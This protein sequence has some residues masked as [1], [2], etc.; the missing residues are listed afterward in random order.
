MKTKLVLKEIRHAVV[1]F[2]VLILGC[3]GLSLIFSEPLDDRITLS[4]LILLKVLGF[5]A[6][7]LARF[8][9]IKTFEP[10]T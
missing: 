8:M 1:F 9:Y 6:V 10:K 4:Y 2:T 7:L 3:I 5:S